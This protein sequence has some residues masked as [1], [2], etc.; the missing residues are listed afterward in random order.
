MKVQRNS[1]CYDIIKKT[2]KYTF[3]H[4]VILFGIIFTVALSRAGASWFSNSWHSRF[5]IQ[6]NGNLISGVLTNYP[7]LIYL[8]NISSLKNGA[9]YDGNDIVFCGSDGYTPLSFEVESYTNGTLYA[10]VRIP[11]LTAGVQTNIYLYF[12][13]TAQTVSISDKI[14]VWDSDY[15]L[16]HHMHNSD[17]ITNYDST[18]NNHFSTNTAASGSVIQRTNGIARFANWL[19]GT[20][21]Y[22]RVPNIALLHPNT[23]TFEA[24]VNR[25]YTNNSSSL[26]GL[27]INNGTPGVH[28]M[29]GS[30]ERKGIIYLNASYYYFRRHPSFTSNT[31]HYYAATV[32]E[33]DISSSAMYKDGALMEHGSV[34]TTDGTAAAKD[35]FTLGGVGNSVWFPGFFD[36][37]RYS[38][39]VRSTNYFA[40]VS[41]N[42]FD[43][44]GFVAAGMHEDSIHV[45][46]FPDPSPAC[47]LITFSNL[48]KF[49][50]GTSVTQIE[51]IFGN[52]RA[53]VYTG[54]NALKPATNIFL[55]NGTYTNSVI[56]TTSDGVVRTNKHSINIVTYREPRINLII[57]PGLPAIRENIQFVDATETYMSPISNW[58]LDLGDGN[59]QFFIGLSK[60]RTGH[61]YA[62]AGIYNVVLT[63]TDF[64]GISFSKS[65]PLSVHD[66]N[67]RKIK[68]L[69]KRIYKKDRDLPLA[70]KY[71]L[72]GAEERV[73]IRVMNIDG[74]LIC[75]L[76]IA[77]GY[78]G[79]DVVFIWNGRDW[80]NNPPRTGP[81]LVRVQILDETKKLDDFI[82]CIVLY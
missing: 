62:R 44:M 66:Y 12:S 8:S 48:T 4:Q 78:P 22:M 17:G 74:M 35:A 38:K 51:Y 82:E 11:I 67:A 76:G 18:A 81:Y 21:G 9:R 63:I 71:S 27:R 41:T 59:S 7:A 3:F 24:W 43:P 29:W 55:T 26:L 37:V 32:S 64:N 20:S 1:L 31:W 77:K 70:F 16:V 47:V 10:W 52:G 80:L 54:S 36:E 6:I 56:V 60:F 65:F 13:N 5:P 75:D 79:T 19:N 68:G 69:E 34:I 28:D 39:I 42:L 30:V 73:Y 23:F 61:T 45:S 53:A 40:A 46:I 57:Y 15:L 33:G 49:F 58:M 14:A 2:L 72:S 25:T 50:P